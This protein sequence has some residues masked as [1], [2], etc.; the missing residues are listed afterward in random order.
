[1]VKTSPDGLMQKY[2]TANASFAGVG[3]LDAVVYSRLYG[4]TEKDAQR[5]IEEI[6]KLFETDHG[7]EE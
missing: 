2:V 7:D 6:K 3:T 5:K 1:M 4:V